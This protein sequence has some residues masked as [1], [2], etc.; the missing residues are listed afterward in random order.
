MAL[1]LFFQFQAHFILLF[2]PGVEVN[3]VHKALFRALSGL[4]L[5]SDSGVLLL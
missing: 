5:I 1:L 4:R 3:V 2:V